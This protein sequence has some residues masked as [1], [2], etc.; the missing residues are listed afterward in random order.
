MAEVRGGQYASLCEFDVDDEDAAFAYAEERMRATPSRLAVTNRASA[1]GNPSSRQL[2][3]GDIDA[4]AAVYSD[5]FVYD[6]RR[7]LGGDPIIGTSAVHAAIER[8]ARTTTDS[9]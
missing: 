9:S 7:R 6:D 3:S 8:F 2:H 4:A 5:N 1:S